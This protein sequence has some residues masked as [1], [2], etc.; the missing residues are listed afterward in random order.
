VLSAHHVIHSS[1]PLVIMTNS[2]LLLEVVRVLC[3]RLLR[4]KP[5]IRHGDVPV[6]PRA[7][8]AVISGLSWEVRE[9]VLAG[10]VLTFSNVHLL[11]IDDALR[12][13][14]VLGIESSIVECNI[15]IP[16]LAVPRVVRP[17]DLSAAP[18][19]AYVALHCIGQLKSGSLSMMQ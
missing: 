3:Y 18:I 4:V 7:V 14:K 9:N 19:G 1:L 2:Q 16:A 5:T 12:R 15:V 8:K 11:A 6:S 10:T 17:V 13:R